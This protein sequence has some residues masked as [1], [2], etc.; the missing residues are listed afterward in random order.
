M[1]RLELLA[2][3]QGNL[4]VEVEGYM[5]LVLEFRHRAPSQGAYLFTEECRKGLL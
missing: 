4:E 1:P 3:L 2:L 5:W